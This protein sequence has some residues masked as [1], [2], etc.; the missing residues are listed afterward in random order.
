MDQKK[1]TSASAKG[2]TAQYGVSP[3]SQG[4]ALT[5][6][7]FKFKSYMPPGSKD[8][9]VWGVLGEGVP[10][11]IQGPIAN[12]AAKRLFAQEVMGQVKSK[13]FRPQSGHK[14]SRKALKRRQSPI[15]IQRDVAF[16]MDDQAEFD[17]LMKKFLPSVKKEVRRGAIN[18]RRATRRVERRATRRAG[19][20]EHM[21]KSNVNKDN[22]IKN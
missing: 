18:T 2:L 15:V 22:K 20:I 12:E 7:E 4:S 17:D 8:K 1:R 6:S 16:D 13:G 10:V 21:S 5:G 9:V 14:F 11:P 19:S 3:R